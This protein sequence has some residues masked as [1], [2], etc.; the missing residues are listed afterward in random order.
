MPQLRELIMGGQI[1]DRGLEPLR[2]MRALRVFEMLWQANITDKGIANLKYCDQLEEVDLLGCNVGD[3][4]IAALTGKP[5]LL[6]FKT[7][8][9]VTDD[10][11]Q[12]L[13]Q[14]PAFKSWQGGEIKYGLMAF[15]GEPTNLLI[16]GPDA[17]TGKFEESHN[18]P[19]IGLLR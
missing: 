17:G 11:L 5:K 12:Q 7:G 1:T 3:G 13:H 4:A 16:D 8:K 2:Q 18:Y 9:N 6:R 19:A 14:F 15:S 10:G